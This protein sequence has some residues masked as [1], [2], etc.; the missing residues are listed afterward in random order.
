MP[1]R[2]FQVLPRGTEP[3]HIWFD[4]YGD[5]RVQEIV[6]EHPELSHWDT[7]DDF[8]RYKLD[9]LCWENVVYGDLLM[10]LA[11]MEKWY[12]ALDNC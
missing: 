4:V 7:F 11:R 6:S 10:E 8:E 1:K 9:A 3:G 2:W 12:Q 5:E